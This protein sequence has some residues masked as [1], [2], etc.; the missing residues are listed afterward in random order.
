MVCRA[1]L[2]AGNVPAWWGWLAGSIEIVK[3]LDMFGLALDMLPELWLLAGELCY[4][5]NRIA[6]WLTASDKMLGFW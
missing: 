2:Q 3:P 6:V 4:T 5:F 1:L